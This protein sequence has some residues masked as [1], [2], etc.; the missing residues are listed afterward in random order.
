MSAEK[1]SLVAMLPSV[2]TYQVES[3]MIHDDHATWSLGN[4]KQSLDQLAD[5]LGGNLIHNHVHNTS[6]LNAT[7]FLEESSCYRVLSNAVCQCLFESRHIRRELLLGKPSYQIC[8]VRQT[9]VQLAW[10]KQHR[11]RYETDAVIEKE[12]REGKR[13]FAFETFSHSIIS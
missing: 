3:G 11:Y 2:C 5:S 4:R 7:F 6:L 1:C 8:F 13:S 12:K 10:T 9:P